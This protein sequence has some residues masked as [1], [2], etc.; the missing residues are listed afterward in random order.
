MK[1]NVVLIKGNV[2]PVLFGWRDLQRKGEKSPRILPPTA[3][4]KEGELAT[5]NHGIAIVAKPAPDATS[6]R[7]VLPLIASIEECLTV[8]N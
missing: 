2:R 4:P 7:P 8:S 6:G 5:N 1:P 3:R